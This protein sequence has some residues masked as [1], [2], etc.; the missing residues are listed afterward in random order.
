MAILFWAGPHSGVFPF[1]RPQQNVRTY[2]IRSFVHTVT[3]VRSYTHPRLRARACR[4]LCQAPPAALS[5]A[6]PPAAAAPGRAGAAHAAPLLRSGSASANKDRL[7]W[8]LGHDLQGKTFHVTTQQGR[9]GGASLALLLRLGCIWM[10]AGAP[11]F[12]PGGGPEQPQDAGDACRPVERLQAVDRGRGW[13]ASVAPSCSCTARPGPARA[14]QPLQCLPSR[15]AP[16]LHSPTCELLQMRTTP[17]S[18]AAQGAAA[19]ASPCT[20]SAT[21]AQTS[22]SAVIRLQGRG[23]RRH[24]SAGNEGW[25]P[26]G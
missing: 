22:D 25:R 7:P 4:V 19:T 20:C 26:R 5:W 10:L 6:R 2:S 16:W 23:T 15:G 1:P 14:L 3:L 21:Q 24:T 11:P 9:A 8:H 13:F 12:A 17:S 18:W